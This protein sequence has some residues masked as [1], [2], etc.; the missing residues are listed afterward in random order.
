LQDSR[1]VLS[2][3]LVNKDSKEISLLQQ[4]HLVVSSNLLRQIR[5]Y[6]QPI[7]LA[8]GVVIGFV[9]LGIVGIFRKPK[10]RIDYRKNPPAN[11]SDSGYID[12]KQL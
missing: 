12:K 4:E 2:A 9:A 5:G 11:A 10:S 3:R 6:L 7:P 1:L 8:A